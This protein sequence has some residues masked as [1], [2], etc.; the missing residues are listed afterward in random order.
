[1][2]FFGPVDNPIGLDISDLSVKLVQLSKKGSGLELAAFSDVP[3]PSGLFNND[4][5]QNEA[6]LVDY[7]QNLFKNVSHH[8]GHLHGRAIVASIPEAKAFVRVINLPMLASEELVT[9]V[10]IEAE[11]YIPLPIDQMQVDWQVVGQSAMGLKVFIT[12]TPKIYVQNLV[13]VFVKAGLVAQSI[14]A[15][16]AAIVRAL[17]P[18]TGQVPGTLIVDLDASRT[19]F[20]VYGD[21][22]IQ[23]TSSI[24]MA[25]NAFTEAIAK[26]LNIDRQ[27][28]EHVKRLH[29]VPTFAGPEEKVSPEMSHILAEVSQAIAPILN[30]L[31]DEIKNTIKFHEEHTDIEHP[32]LMKISQII[33]CGGTAKL[34]NLVEYLQGR[35]TGDMTFSGRNIKVAFANAWQN[36]IENA[37]PPFSRRE[38]F[39]YTTAI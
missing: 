30:N 6:G 37:A 1:M 9:A 29:G 3:L 12:A 33:L 26:R 18:K 23:F 2:K 32:E 36:V 17:L 21:N 19:S 39:S 15:E 7:L 20:I 28:A 14:E 5:I 13:N 11:Q 24:P 25:G 38:A 34:P 27:E 4:A 10:P 31:Y 22:S 8:S 35:I 16:S